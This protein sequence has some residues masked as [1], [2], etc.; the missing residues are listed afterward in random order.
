M[1]YLFKNIQNYFNCPQHYITNISICSA[2]AKSGHSVLQIDPASHYGGAWASLRLDELRTALQAASTVNGTN[3]SLG[4]D[5]AASLRPG[6]VLTRPAAALSPPSSYSLDLLPHL[7]YG[8]GPMISLLLGSGAHHY[9]EY[10]LVQGTLIRDPS[11]GVYQPV[12]S[13]RAEVFRDRTLTPLQKRTFMRFL[14]GCAEAMEG[15]GPLIDRL[16]DGSFQQLMEEEELDEHLQRSLA[17]GVLLCHAALGGDLTGIE[18][19]KLFKLYLESVGRY[20]VDTGPFLTP[21][22]GCGELP[23]AFCRS[24]AVGGAVQVLR[25]GIAGLSFDEHTFTCTGIE[26]EETGQIIRGSKLAAGHAV[27]HEW[28]QT[29][30]LPTQ[31]ITTLRCVAVVDAPVVA[32]K[33]QALIV[34]PEAGPNTSTVWVLQLSHGTAVCPEGQWV[35]H[36]WCE[37]GNEEQEE[38]EGENTNGSS[39]ERYLM[40]CLEL[41]AECNGLEHEQES[42]NLVSEAQPP[43]TH[44]EAAAQERPNVL[45][46]AFFSLSTLKVEGEV[47]SSWPS[48]VCLCPGPSPDVTLSGAVETAKQCYWDLFP[49]GEP[50][51][52]TSEENNAQQRHPPV[53]P[54]DEGAQSGRGG[55]GEVDGEVPD[56]G[57]GGDSDDEAV[58]AL[59]AALGLTSPQSDRSEAGNVA[60]G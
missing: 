36:L 14:K 59:Q 22:Y 33:A 25:C 38:E 30:F 40:P 46:T 49:P 3:T 60:E 37:G 17:H 11:T 6:R 21:M 1:I 31:Q 5:C 12:P 50:A 42:S 51:F 45:F 4:N 54:L 35:L 24:A 27:L 34:L 19:L 2:A 41:L 44:D 16:G 53:F 32:D 43:I 10:K 48:N 56:G 23:Q 52:D 9:T 20:G 7:L 13:T 57:G 28:A 26:L 55:N 39:A 29:F 8:A 15:R 18:A 58:Q 47:P